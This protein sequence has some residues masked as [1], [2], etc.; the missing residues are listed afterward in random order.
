MPYYMAQFCLFVIELLGYVRLGGM[1]PEIQVYGEISIYLTEIL[2][3][4]RRLSLNSMSR[5]N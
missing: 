5:T 2:N 3:T 1:L 4:V